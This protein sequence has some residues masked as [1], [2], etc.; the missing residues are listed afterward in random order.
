MD[1]YSKRIN[2]NL[3]F[4][5][6]AVVKAYKSSHSLYALESELGRVLKL[7]SIFVVILAIVVPIF[8]GEII[9]L[10]LW[11][12]QFSLASLGLL[13]G[14]SLWTYS[15]YLR[16]DK[17]RYQSSGSHSLKKLRKLVEKS[18][19]KLSSEEAKPS[20]IGQVKVEQYMGASL[21]IL[22]GELFDGHR[23]E[24]SESAFRSFVEALIKLPSINTI[25]LRLGIL[26]EQQAQLIYSLTELIEA[27][28]E[29]QWSQLIID[30]FKYALDNNFAYLDERAF[31]LTLMTKLG[32][33]SQTLFA[34]DEEVITSVWQWIATED[35]LEDLI[36]RIKANSIFTPM[37]TVNAAMT[38]VYS[39]TV[40]KYCSDITL[41]L[42]EKPL[43][44]LALTHRISALKSVIT[45]LASENGLVMLAGEPGVGKTTLIES[46]AAMILA[47]TLP[48]SLQDRRLLNLNLTKLLSDLRSTAD[49]ATQLQAIFNE[50]Q[51]SGNMIL[52]ID[53]FDQLLNLKTDLQQEVV[54]MLAGEMRNVQVKLLA[55]IT[56]A[57]YKRHI[58]Q[59]PELASM[60]VLVELPEAN[61]ATTVQVMADELP[62]LE[63]KYKVKI[64]FPALKVI[65]ELSKQ[66]DFN[67]FLPAKAILALEEIM[68]AARTDGL[69]FATV[70]Y[71][72]EFMEKKIG[73]RLGVGKSQVDEDEK[74]M[75]EG[76]EN[77]IRK[78]IIA[79]NEAISNVARALRRARVGM[80][81]KNKPTA[82]FM[83]YG[84]TGVGKTELAKTVAKVYFGTDNLVL[85]LDMSEFQQP[86]DINKLLGHNEGGT[87]VP[88][89]LSQFVLE[90]PYCLVI[91][92]ELEKADYRILDLFLQILDN[93][94]ITDGA[95]R[96][97]DF[98][99]AI[100]V[101]TSNAGSAYIFEQ[102][103][104][105]KSYKDIE[106]EASTFLQKSFRVEFL[107]R[108]DA[109]VMFH[110]LSLA[111]AE[112]VTLL[113]L[114]TEKLALQEK[115]IE[116]VYTDKLVK[117]IVEEG[118][119]REFGARSLKRKV[120]EMVGDAVADALIAGTLKP[121][122]IF[123]LE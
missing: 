39:P 1:S 108:F 17:N 65:A 31:L 110:P 86:S 66:N 118:F 2:T 69:D 114:E 121:G 15:R 6:G 103:K 3:S 23:A 25:Q 98:S 9:F 67:K 12:R 61:I 24:K 104:T 62:S 37:Q 113:L 55:T 68:M 109:V 43:D 91:L 78:H 36:T 44:S 32:P 88:G 77:E 106:K 63:A 40:E 56:P 102:V 46:L 79:Q 35:S 95:G 100:L 18:A 22:L 81:K 120:T 76:L 53:D 84:P 119:T 30:S 33:E 4:A 42:R 83:F 59:L 45:G 13:S 93:A 8:R 38:S 82:A 52:V 20:T 101:A 72:E 50:Q 28:N 34:I 54:A 122:D 11:D 117:R 85:R 10:T 99:H 51:R 123:S 70:E 73:L 111:D 112:A 96:E 90:H 105:G 60:F 48:Q 80:N 19:E 5:A 58:E 115:G 97:V 89:I 87:Y 116:F 27:G 57:N 16:R 41:E 47:R 74:L 71:I 7:V 21:T 75:L 92:D 94:K 14:I 64:A 29:E 26:P 49:I 107:N